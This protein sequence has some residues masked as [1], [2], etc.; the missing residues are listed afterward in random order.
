MKIAQV[1]PPWIAIPPQNYGGTEN[2]ISNLVEALVAKGHDVTLFTTGDSNTSAKQISF[3]A[4]ALIASGV[5]WQAHLKAY[6]HLYKSIEYIKAHD[7]DI[8]HMHLSSTPDLYIFPLSSELDIPHVTTLHS[9]FPFD[10]HPSGWIGDADDYFIKD[11]GPSKPL[12]AIS[13]SA[14]EQA[15]DGLYFAGVVHNGILMSQFQPTGQPE[16]YFAWMGR[17][18]PAKGAHLAIQA[19]KAARVR[20]I[21]AGIVSR[22]SRESMQYFQEFIEPQIDNKQITYI[23]PV[24]MQQKIDLL[25]RARAFLNPIQWEE[26][27]GMVMIESMALGCPVI[28]FAR[29]AAPEIIV[30]RKTGFLVHDV[31]DMVRFIPRIDEISR[32][33]TRQHVQQNFSARAMAEK[34][35]KIYQKIIMANKT[36][37]RSKTAARTAHSRLIRSSHI[38]KPPIAG[39]T[40]HEINKWMER[41][42]DKPASSQ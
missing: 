31:D 8:V 35:V 10:N 33:T 19:A 38:I 9:H 18:V 26:P 2:V 6:Y 14:Q 24:N 32:E 25:S 20:L 30:H 21:L 42:E 34:Y 41:T 5:P 22:G 37:A 17:F 40:V 1:A 4:Q 3:L 12:V 27:F 39:G 29:G 11:W 28:A 13:E 36:A 7:F 15:P 16:D 23:G